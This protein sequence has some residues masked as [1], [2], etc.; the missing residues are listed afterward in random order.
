MVAGHADFEAEGYDAIS[1]AMA[2]AG[3]AKRLAQLPDH[4]PLPT[5][6]EMLAEAAEAPERIKEKSKE[7]GKGR[8][9][10]QEL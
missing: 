1:G 7:Q 3:E 5:K 10:K 8:G 9:R 2:P 6:A 4:R